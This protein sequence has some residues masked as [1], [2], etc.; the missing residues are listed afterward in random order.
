MNVTIG[1]GQLQQ[2]GS[3][4]VEMSSWWNTFLWQ[5]TDWSYWQQYCSSNP[6]GEPYAGPNYPGNYPY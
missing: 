2:L 5:I 1:A 3:C 6:C 4:T